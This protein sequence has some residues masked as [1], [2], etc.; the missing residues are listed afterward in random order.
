MPVKRMAEHVG[1]LMGCA[2]EPG[3]HY[4]TAT[5]TSY[6]LGMQIH[7]YEWRGR[8]D[9]PIL[10]FHGSMSRDRFG[11]DHLSQESEIVVERIDQGV[12]DLLSVHGAGD[13]RIPS[14]ADIDAEIAYGSYLQGIRPEW[15]GD[16]FA[17]EEG[18]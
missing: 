17:S 11:V 7:L 4:E 3:Y 9:T 6:L 13:W 2:F 8:G 10:R 12:I 15:P 16:E 14:E 18:E 1:R 5:W